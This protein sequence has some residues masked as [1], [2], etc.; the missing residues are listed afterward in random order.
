M[1]LPRPFAATAFARLAGAPVLRGDGAVGTF[2]LLACGVFGAQALFAAFKLRGAL[3]SRRWPRVPGLVTGTSIEE[4]TRSQID[5]DEV[6]QWTEYV[7]HVHYTYWQG[8]A[9]RFGRAEVAVRRTRDAARQQAA[10]YPVGRELRVFSDPRRPQRSTLDPG[11]D[12]RR[13]LKRLFSSSVSIAL[14]VFVASRVRRLLGR[15]LR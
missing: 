4:V 15:L 10:L 11:A 1:A 12:A 7:T 3:A 13:A 8:T 5:R 6:H 2:V 14:V 9:Y